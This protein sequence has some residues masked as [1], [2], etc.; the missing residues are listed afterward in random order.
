MNKRINLKIN[1]L[2]IIK[3]INWWISELMCQWINELIN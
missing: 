1:E 3:P 2:S